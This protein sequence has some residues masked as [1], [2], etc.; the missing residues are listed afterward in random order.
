ML[1]KK[2][3]KA[4]RFEYVTA[5]EKVNEFCQYTNIANLQILNIGMFLYH[6]F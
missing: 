5:A 2:K 4:E 1:K 3:K 6:P